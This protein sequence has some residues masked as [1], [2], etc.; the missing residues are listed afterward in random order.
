MGSGISCDDAANPT[1]T[2]LFQ[3]CGDGA[4]GKV[5]RTPGGSLATDHA[6]IVY[7]VKDAGIVLDEKGPFTRARIDHG[8][9]PQGA[10]Y[11]YYMVPKSGRKVAERLLAAD[12]PIEVLRQDGSAHII[13]SRTDGTVCAALFDAAAEYPG[14]LV[15]GVNIPLAYIL[16]EQDGG[17]YRLSL[18]E[19]DMRRPSVDHM[20]QLTEVQVVT[21][22]QPFA[23]QLH[24]QGTFNVSC[25]EGDVKATCANGETTL[26]LTTVRGR[27]YTIELKK[28]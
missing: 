23:T 8:V 1:V 10:S 5:R 26:D 3:S 22:E 18:C 19:P 4:P 27:N 12:S 2:T 15:K 20:G 28:R 6:G 16:Q 7:A 21:P 25:P 24:L 13:R 9:A 14:L 17:N 11:L